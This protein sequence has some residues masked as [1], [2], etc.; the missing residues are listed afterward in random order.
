V[1]DTIDAVVM[2]VDGVLTDGSFWWNAE[3]EELK[4][5]HFLDVM[6]VSLGRKAG[7][8]FGLITGET[9]PFA[10]MFARKMAIAE[11]HAGCKEKAG[12]LRLIAER[13]AISLSN[14]C[15]IGDDVNDLPAMEIVGLSAAPANAHPLVRQAAD[16][17]L[18]AY[19]GNG[20]VRELIDHILSNYRQK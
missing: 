9:T 8:V 2:D 7:L 17:K 20:A 12:A 1:S 5:F 11:L 10:E 15:Y 6:G 13:Q 18:A 19:G 14:I 3:G 16:L 4:R